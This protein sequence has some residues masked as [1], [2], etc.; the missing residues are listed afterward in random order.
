MND[1]L[2]EAEAGVFLGWSIATM[3]VNR[4]NGCGPAYYRWGRRILYRVSDLEQFVE[5]S[6]VQPSAS[7]V[8]KARRM[9]NPAVNDGRGNGQRIIV[10]AASAA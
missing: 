7:P 8:T 10:R 9:S 1:F 6:R 5:D 3:R 4:R 2:T